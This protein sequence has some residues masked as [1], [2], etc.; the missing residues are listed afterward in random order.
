MDV[1]KEVFPIV[2]YFLGSVLL[3]VLIYLLLKLIST[4]DKINEILDNVDKKVKTLDGLF[5]AIDKITGGISSFG[6]KIVDIALN[7]F[8][9]VSKKKKRK[10][11][12]EDEQKRTR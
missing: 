4:V 8:S 7:I 10:E 6:D 2:L 1:L 12:I 9:K 5:N 3:V 11:V